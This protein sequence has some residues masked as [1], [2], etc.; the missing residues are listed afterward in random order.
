MAQER[1]STDDRVM[2]HSLDGEWKLNY[3][4]TDFSLET[5][6]VSA[7]QVDLDDRNWFD[8]QVPGEIH[9]EM[10]KAGVIKDPNY[11]RNA[12]ECLWMED[13]EWWYRKTFNLPSGFRKSRIELAFQG[14]DGF[15]NIYLNGDLVAQ[16]DNMYMPCRTDITG[17][18]NYDG[19]NVLAVRFD[20]TLRGTLSRVRDHEFARRSQAFA[21]LPLISDPSRVYV[22][23]CA[24]NWGWDWAPRLVTAG[25]WR[26]VSLQAIDRVAVRDV[27]VR[28][29]RVDRNQADVEV[30]ISLENCTADLVEAE[31]TLEVRC[32]GSHLAD[33]FTVELEP[34]EATLTKEYA[35]ND[36]K[37]WWPNGCGEQNLYSLDLYVK[38]E[39]RLIAGHSSR[40]GLRTVEL[41]KR[42]DQTPDG[43]AFYFKVNGKKI[44]CKGTN[45]GQLDLLYPRAGED[46]YEKAL[47]MARESHYTMFRLNGSNIP[48]EYDV[49]YDLCDEMGIM[50]WQDFPYSCAAYPQD[51][52][53]LD[54]AR[55]EGEQIVKRLRNHPCL[56]IWCG[57]N[58]IEGFD[59]HNKVFHQVLPEVCRRLTPGVPY[60]PLSPFGSERHMGYVHRETIVTAEPRFVSEFCFQAPPCVETLRSFTHDEVELW[61]IVSPRSIWPYRYF[62]PLRIA[63]YLHRDFGLTTGGDRGRGGPTGLKDYVRK[64]Q[65]IQAENLRVAGEHLRRQKFQCGGALIWSYADPWPSTTWTLLDYYLIPKMSYYFVKRAYSPVLLSFKQESDRRLSVWVTSDRH[66]ALK[67]IVEIRHMTFLGEALWKKEIEIDMPPNSSRSVTE[68]DMEDLAHRDPGSGF[69]HGSVTVGHRVISENTFFSVRQKDLSLPLS[70]IEVRLIGSEVEAT[71]KYRLQLECSANRFARLVELKVLPVVLGATPLYSDNYFDILPDEP[72]TVGIS[73]QLEGERRRIKLRVESEN[74]KPLDLVMTI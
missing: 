2:E 61:P 33:S 70:E 16:H 58:E 62:K 69:L 28:P 42:S 4:P 1:L 38:E 23:K 68:V 46:K 48:I 57:G 31:I 39:Q 49:F 72:K 26:S 9:I 43:D 18:L 64:T 10:I 13:C 44:F 36:A 22:R 25:I 59:P 32:D 19:E 27:Y 29:V 6:L 20:S 55:R 71:G 50:V 73:G 52:E 51:D 63:I 24:C 47:E 67:G 3:Y 21:D 17:K 35:I 60:H 34:G 15:A 37:L 53:F 14:L 8:C 5:P 65:F 54:L 41:V 45:F 30:E 74:S 66:E 40:F 7:E 11:G 56:A 12:D